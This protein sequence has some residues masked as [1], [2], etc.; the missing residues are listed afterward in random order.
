M[1]KTILQVDFDDDGGKYFVTAAQNS[2]VS[3]IAFDISVIIK[4]LVRDKHIND[5]KEMLDLIG[6]Y[7]ADEQYEEVK[8]EQQTDGQNN[9]QPTEQM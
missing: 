5:N 6:K 2:S 9:Q 3:E 7:L 8:D 1:K 4:C